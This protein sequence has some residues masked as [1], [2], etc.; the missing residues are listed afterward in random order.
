MSQLI[1]N[2]D[3]KELE[4]SLKD[5]AKKNKKALNQVVIDAIKQFIG[6]PDDKKI[7]YIKKGR[8]RT[9]PHGNILS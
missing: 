7:K 4:N 1:L 5:F 3:N 2:L 9:S 8:I 6:V